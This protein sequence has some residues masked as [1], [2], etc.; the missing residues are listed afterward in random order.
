MQIAAVTSAAEA[1]IAAADGH[2][3]AL[4][5]VLQAAAEHPAPDE[6]ARAA[7]LAKR[8]VRAVAGKHLVST[9]AFILMATEVSCLA[10]HQRVEQWL[11]EGVAIRQTAFHLFNV[12]IELSLQEA[13]KA[14]AATSAHEPCAE[15][16]GKS[17]S[18]LLEDIV[19]RVATAT[20]FLVEL[21]GPSGSK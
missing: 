4:R 19:G 3:L 14:G 20:G 15:Y 21:C 11:I 2:M 8:K 12:S 1:A 13:L 18:E 17:D 5:P 16:A 10:G 9:A 6:A 7:L